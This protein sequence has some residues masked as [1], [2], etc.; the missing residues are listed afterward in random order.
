MA[1]EV[2]GALQLGPL[3]ENTDP[4]S[5]ERLAELPPIQRVEVEGHLIEANPAVLRVIQLIG[6]HARTENV[7]LHF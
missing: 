3:P 4:A 6:Q 7:I 1:R 2:D 5:I